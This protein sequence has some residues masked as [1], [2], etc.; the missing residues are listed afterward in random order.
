LNKE[1][2]SV[3]ISERAIQKIF[4]AYFNSFGGI[5][6]SFAPWRE[7]EWARKRERGRKEER[8]EERK[9]EKEEVSVVSGGRRSERF[10]VV[11]YNLMVSY[12]F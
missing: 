6:D 4:G 5:S 7:R 12:L 9:R 11:A 8:E 2:F 3:G 10:G 1:K